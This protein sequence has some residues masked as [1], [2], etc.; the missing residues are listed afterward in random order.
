M[1]KYLVI[2]GTIRSKTDGDM[3]YISPARLCF[4]YKVNPSECVVVPDGSFKNL[5]RYAGT[6][7]IVLAPRLDGDYALPNA[8]GKGREAK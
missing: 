1:K 8:D 2:G 6:N 7:L 3:H 4:L 5:C